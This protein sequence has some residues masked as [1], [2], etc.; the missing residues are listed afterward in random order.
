MKKY[1]LKVLLVSGGI[2]CGLICAEMVFRNNPAYDYKNS[3]VSESVY[4]D[5]SWSHCYRKS[6][7]LG[8]ELIPNSSNSINSLG[9]RDKEYPK[10]KANDNYRI[11]V[12]GDSI[13]EMGKWHSIIENRLNAATNYD[14]YEVLNAGVSGWNLYQYWAYLKYKGI[15][16]NPD[17]VILGI[18]LNDF[19]GWEDVRT[20]L[21]DRKTNTT[22]LFNVK[23]KGQYCLK[24][25]LHINPYLYKNICLYRFIIAYL[26]SIKSDKL[27]NDAAHELEMLLKMKEMMRERIVCIVFPYL[28]LLSKYDQKELHQYNM[29]KE[30]LLKANIDYLDL[31]P[32]FNAYNEKI[33]DFRKWPNDKIHFNDEAD[34]INA[35]LIYQWLKKFHVY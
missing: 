28:K 32:V 1:I 3:I 17:L 35:N 24:S 14:K 31:T 16:L 27:E 15:K 30:I 20:I 19:E 4:T 23:Q 9:M 18:C 2:I 12:I 10:K 33:V 22:T 11:L 6:D 13:T 8:Y 7:T 5:D 34:S 26:T 29:T 21:V 25:T